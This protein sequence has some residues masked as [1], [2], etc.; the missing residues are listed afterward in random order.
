MLSSCCGFIDEP[1]DAKLRRSVEGDLLAAEL[2]GG[3]TDDDY[4]ARSRYVLQEFEVEETD[5]D[6][7]DSSE[8]LDIE[9]A[10]KMLDG[11]YLPL[12]HGYVRTSDGSWLIACRTDLG[13]ECTGKHFDWWFCNCDNTERYRWW[14]PVDHVVGEWNPQY[15]STQPEDRKP[16]HY[17]GH[18]H[19]VKEKINGIEQELFIEFERPSKHFETER[20]QDA[21]V[22][23]CVCG[24]IYLFD[25]VIGLLRI[26]NLIHMVRLNSDG[27]SELRSRFWIGDVRKIR[28]AGSVFGRILPTSL[29]NYLG[30]TYLFRLLRAPKSLARGIWLHCSQEMTC[31]R[32]FLPHFYQSRINE[33]KRNKLEKIKIKI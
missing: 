1:I 21:N 30:N 17:I 11:G 14:H 20:F 10:Y 9:C 25:K 8:Y 23:A 6:N 32:E 16:G 15:Y 3:A 18:V 31:L 19:K 5:N 7:R 13:Q 4:I 27:N 22:T 12:E 28:S 24:K 29:I 2:I 33:Y 26:G